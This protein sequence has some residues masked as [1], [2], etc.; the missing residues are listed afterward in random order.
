MVPEQRSCVSTSDG[1]NLNA[2]SSLLGLMH[3]IKC[4]LVELRS[5]IKVFRSL[6]KRRET[7]LNVFAFFTFASSAKSWRST[8]WPEPEHSA[9]K[10][11]CSVS[12]FLSQKPS[13]T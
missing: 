9:T 5:S 7:E 6:M 8:P 3:R 1:V 10:S 2:S 4:A 11:E 12:L 13:P